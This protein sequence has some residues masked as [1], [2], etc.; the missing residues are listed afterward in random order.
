MLWQ[1]R[2][3]IPFSKLSGIIFG[4]FLNPLDTGRP[5]GFSL[6]DVLKEHTQ[7]LDIPVV[8]NAPFGHGDTLHPIPIGS[9]ASLTAEPGSAALRLDELPVTP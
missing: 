7:G 4:Q 5:F 2:N 3:S 9:L 8:M 6:E 1:L